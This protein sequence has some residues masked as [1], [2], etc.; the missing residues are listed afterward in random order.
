MSRGTPPPPVRAYGHCSAVVTGFGIV[1]EA[2][3][4]VSVPPWLDALHVLVQ[5][6]S[7]VAPCWHVRLLPSPIVA[8]QLLP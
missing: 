6:T 8:E 5:T 3:F 7:Q 4:T 2:H 1:S